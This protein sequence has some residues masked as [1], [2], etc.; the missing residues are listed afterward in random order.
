MLSRLKI[1][2]VSVAILAL[3]LAAC[4]DGFESSMKMTSKE[5]C[6]VYPNDP[7]CTGGIGGPGANLVYNTPTADGV[8][9]MVQSN[10]NNPDFGE[11]YAKVNLKNTSAQPLSGTFDVD[12]GGNNQPI[13]LLEVCSRANDAAI[14]CS[15][16]SAA[17]TSINIPAGGTGYFLIR[18]TAD[19]TIPYVPVV[20]KIYLRSNTTETSVNGAVMIPIANEK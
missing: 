13:T 2:Q 1:I 6:D 17:Q 3:S 15:G 7:D 4:D 18:I 8:I 12:Q 11:G 20:N 9:R 19:G 16:T 14:V 10:P 5:F